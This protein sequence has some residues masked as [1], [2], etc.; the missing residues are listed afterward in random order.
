MNNKLIFISNVSRF[1]FHFNFRRFNKGHAKWLQSISASRTGTSNVQHRHFDSFF[2]IKC[3]NWYLF[4][5][6]NKLMSIF[7]QYFQYFNQ[8]FVFKVFSLCRWHSNV[9]VYT[10]VSLVLWLLG[11]FALILCLWWSEVHI[12]SVVDYK[13]LQWIIQNCVI[14][15]LKLVHVNAGNFPISQGF[16][17]FSIS[18]RCF[19]T[20]S[21]QL[22]LFRL[23]SRKTANFFLCVTQIG[24]CGVYFV[25]VAKNIQALL[26]QYDLDV[27]YYLLMLL[28]PMILL[29]FLKNLKYLVP[30]SI[31]ASIL[32]ITG[33]FK[34]IE[35]FQP[36]N[37]FTVHLQ[38]S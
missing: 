25:F 28:P 31:L 13:N 27:R 36:K 35:I 8:I 24:F 17:L 5:C 23:I 15:H 2:K 26:H 30:I 11:L 19:S 32:S 18:Y 33:K 10:L 14:L 22:K 4:S 12:N 34:N 37:W 16:I 7:G 29:N 20:L 6:Y 9:L 1:N 38:E 21:M 3:W